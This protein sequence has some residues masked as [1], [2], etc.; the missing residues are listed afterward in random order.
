MKD[1]KNTLEQMFFELLQVAI[2]RIVCLSH[3][4]SAEEWKGLYDMAK[5]QS[6]VG[7]CFAG[8]QKL[9]AQRQEPPEM[10]YLTWMGMAAKIQQRNEVVNRQCAELQE[11][12][13]ADGIISS[14]MKG[15]AIAQLYSDNLKT[16]RQS[17][18]IDIYVD[19]GRKAAIQ[20]AKKAQKT[21]DWDYKHLHLDVFKDTEV[22][23]HYRTEMMFNVF[24][25]KAVRQ[26]EESEEIRQA[27]FAENLNGIVTA[28]P[29]FNLVY[30]LMH[31]YNHAMSEGC[32]LR[33]F[34]DYYFL[35]KTINVDEYKDTANETINRLG[36]KKFAGGVMWVLH[37][38]FGLEYDR[39]LL[40]AN[41]QAGKYLLKDAMEGGNFGKHDESRHWGRALYPL[42]LVCDWF[43]RDMRI[44]WNV[45]SEA[46]WYPVWVVYHFFWKRVWGWKHG[47]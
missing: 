5:K 23:M 40:P 26:W 41:E 16:L 22:E 1:T 46:M 17:G 35:L 42:K 9:Q 37:E 4:P 15:Q 32:G 12:L 45:S 27:V 25:N 36:M 31:M 2:G 8:V 43:T 6:L 28:S 21:V 39:M 29:E 38:V 20:Y 47:V 18:D 11:Q 19:C 34:M 44:L 7:I 30:L 14:V 33:Q 3:S 24:K 13:R 10:L